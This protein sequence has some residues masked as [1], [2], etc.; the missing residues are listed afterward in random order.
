MQIEPPR[1]GVSDGPWSGS[2]ADLSVSAPADLPFGVGDRL[3]D[4]V[5]PS[6]EDGR[7][8]SL[9]GFRGR[10]LLLHFFASW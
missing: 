6:V 5:L 7:P 4:L 1:Y 3:P 8:L 9:S 10:H 2:W